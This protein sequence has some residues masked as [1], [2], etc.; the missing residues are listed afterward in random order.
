MNSWL[1]A[2]A[3]ILLCAGCELGGRA[4]GPDASW[5]DAAA[6]TED[7]TR[8]DAAGRDAGTPGPDAALPDAA[9]RDAGISGPDAALPDASV[10]DAGPA[11]WF[12][13]PAN[14]ATVANPVLFEIGARGVEQVQVFADQTWPLAPAWDPAARTTLLY[15]FSGTGTPRSLRLVGTVAG[16]VVA[17]AALTITVSPD[18]CADRFF[19]SEFDQHNVDPSGQMDLVALRED[20]LAALKA[21]LETLRQ[22]GATLTLGGMTSLLL[23]EGGLRVAAYN[24]KCVENSYNPTSSDCDAVAEALYS[25]QFGIGAIHTS[26]FHPCKGGSYTQ[27]MR[28]RFIDDAAKAGFSVDPALMTAELTARFRTICATATP[29]AVDYYILAAHSVFGVPKNASGNH[30]AGYGAFPFFTPSV[31][32]DLVFHELSS[33]CASMTS[34]RAA[35][36]AFGGADASYQTTAKQDQILAAWVQF[37]AANCP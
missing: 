33:S 30:L 21:E 16:S 20:S 18:D 3:P 26:N 7:A 6:E 24:T 11:V 34:D 17:E 4:G 12:V 10:P 25:Y 31:S 35:I 32:I 37:S 2:L 9:G 13:A 29:T 27:G 1:L 28:Q 22:C 5:R 14:Q 15:R 19:V 36:A 23:W 8:P